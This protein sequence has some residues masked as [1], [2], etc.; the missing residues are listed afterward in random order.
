MFVLAG[1]NLFCCFL[2]TICALSCVPFYFFAPV[3]GLL[4]EF[5]MLVGLVLEFGSISCSIFM[6]VVFVMDLSVYLFQLCYFLG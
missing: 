3:G 1:L 4:I 5:W 2:S 6:F